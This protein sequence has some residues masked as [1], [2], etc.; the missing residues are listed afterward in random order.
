MGSKDKLSGVSVVMIA[1][2]EEAKIAAALKALLWADEI[3]VIDGQSRDR[4][5][6]IARQFT[7]HVFEQPWLG[8]GP[9]KNVGIDRAAYPWILVVDCDERIG[10]A[11]RDEILRVISAPESGGFEGFEIS[12]R[13][14]LGGRWIR[15]AGSFPDYQLRLF[16]RGAARYNDTPVH[17]NLVIRGAVGRLSHPM[18]HDPGRTIGEHVR[19]I[20]FYTDQLV[21]QVLRKYGRIRWYHF[22]LHPFSTFLK[23][24]VLKRGY[25]DGVAGFTLSSL[26]GLYS[27]SK[28]VKAWEAQ[29]AKAPALS[30]GRAQIF[31]G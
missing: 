29:R 6:E 30:Q 21:A 14:Y 27:F 7:P 8:F 18:D 19:R 24:Y 13:N 10:P 20:H 25:R 2:N 23:L 12:R 1:K 15:G 28:L 31:L 17:E 16:K 5:A 9:Q 26:S 3:I 22:L 11:L 4:T